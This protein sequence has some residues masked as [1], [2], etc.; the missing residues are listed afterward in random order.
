M[1]ERKGFKTRLCWTAIVFKEVRALVTRP[2]D[3]GTLG[4]ALAIAELRMKMKS[5]QYLRSLYFFLSHWTQQQLKWILLAKKPPCISV[6][7]LITCLI[8]PM[9]QAVVAWSS[10]MAQVAFWKP[11]DM[12]FFLENLSSEKAISY[13]HRFVVPLCGGQSLFCFLH[14]HSHPP[15]F[16]YNVFSVFGHQ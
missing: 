11:W 10:P 9:P 6:L 5:Q 13:F 2:E 4:T 8:C 7:L 12:S 1:C 15:Y 3:P 14:C 16:L